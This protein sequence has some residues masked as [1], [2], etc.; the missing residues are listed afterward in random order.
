MFK[1]GLR[2]S[3]RMPS[4]FS[5]WDQLCVPESPIFGRME[6]CRAAVLL[7]SEHFHSLMRNVPLHHIYRLFSA[8]KFHTFINQIIAKLSPPTLSREVW[9]P[10]FFNWRLYP[11]SFPSLGAQFLSY[12]RA[13]PC[14]Q[15]NTVGWLWKYSNEQMSCSLRWRRNKTRCVMCLWFPDRK[16]K[17]EESE[18][19]L[20][21]KLNCYCTEITI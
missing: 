18:Y 14:V 16:W 2:R 6:L 17:W 8:C 13:W 7:G 9:C 21:I 4:N 10:F 15:L 19:R 3:L 11:P 1:L 5:F 20:P 12:W